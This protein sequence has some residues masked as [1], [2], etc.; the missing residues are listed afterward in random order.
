VLE[1]LLPPPMAAAYEQIRPYGFILLYALLLLGVFSAIFGPV[2]M[3]I[4]I[5]LG[6]QRFG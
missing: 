5:L 3:L 6:V 4:E 1:E 2:R